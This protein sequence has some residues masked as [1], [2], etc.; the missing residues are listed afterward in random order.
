[1]RDRRQREGRGDRAC[2]KQTDSELPPN[3]HRASYQ[4]RPHDHGHEVTR[5]T[6]ISGRT[7]SGIARGPLKTPITAVVTKL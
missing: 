3:P 7:T 4:P 5:V 2:H 6:T 1:M